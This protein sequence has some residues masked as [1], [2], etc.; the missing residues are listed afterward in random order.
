MCEYLSVSGT[1]EKAYLLFSG[2]SPT[3]TLQLWSLLPEYWP[4]SKQSIVVHA[5]H[6]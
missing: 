3:S 4:E 5:E 6:S 2:F 1:R